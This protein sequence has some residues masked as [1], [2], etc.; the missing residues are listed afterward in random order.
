[1]QEILALF[2]ANTKGAGLPKDFSFGAIRASEDLLFRPIFVRSAVVFGYMLLMGDLSPNFSCAKGRGT[3]DEEDRT[4]RENAIEA[5]R[6]L[7]A[8]NGWGHRSRDGTTFP[9]GFT[10][11]KAARESY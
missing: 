2:K 6:V 5:T 8:E 10:Y 11:L 4:K 3:V 1:M 9:E 7:F